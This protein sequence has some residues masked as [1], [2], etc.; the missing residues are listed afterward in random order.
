MGEAADRLRANI[1]G[2]LTAAEAQRD[3]LGTGMQSIERC[4]RKLHESRSAAEAQIK[5][6]VAS[7]RD[8]LV[9]S[10]TVALAAVGR[11]AAA[12]C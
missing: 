1:S 8:G 2:A 3:T 5:S 4:V 6:T 7:V 9:A 10:V 12:A 11:C